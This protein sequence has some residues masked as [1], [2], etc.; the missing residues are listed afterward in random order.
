M[1][2]EMLAELGPRER[3]TLLASLKTCVRSLHAGFPD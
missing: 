2:E 1:E 3:A